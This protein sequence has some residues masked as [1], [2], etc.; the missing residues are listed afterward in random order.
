MIQFGITTLCQL[1]TAN[2]YSRMGSRR[3]IDISLYNQ[4][5]DP[6]LQERVLL[7]F[8]GSSGVYRRTYAHRF[9]RFDE[10]ILRSIVSQLSFDPCLVLDVGASDGRSSLNLYHSL[11]GLNLGGFHFT[12]SDPQPRVLIVKR[13]RLS[14]AID[15]SADVLQIVWPPFVLGCCGDG[16]RPINALVRRALREPVRRL[17]NAYLSYEC[18]ARTVSLQ[19]PECRAI[20]A[21]HN[22]F[23]FISFDMFEPSK[24]RYD[25]IRAMNVL[26]ASYFTTTEIKIAVDNLRSM[27]N[28]GGL[29][30]TGRNTGPG[31]PVSG[32]IYQKVGGMMRKLCDADAPSPL[33]HYLNGG[34]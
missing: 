29:L 11:R 15:S 32:S 28:E 2:L 3:H 23:S 9:D 22:D 13:G 20:M 33:R 21:E 34:K 12:A 25:V 24:R 26:N 17:L 16:Y 10:Q 4:T 27:L 19:C 7:N 30:V 14:I 18:S 31:S 5:D 6:K 8:A 1:K